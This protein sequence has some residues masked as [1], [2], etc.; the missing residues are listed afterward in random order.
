MTEGKS[1]LLIPLEDGNGSFTDLIL[2]NVLYAP[3]LKFN[4]ISTRKL[5]K[6]GTVTYLMENDRPAQLMYNGKIIGLAKTVDDQY[7]LQT[8]SSSYPSTCRHLSKEFHPH[9]A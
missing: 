1:S 9:L 4:L 5:G 6:K 8:I 3:R 2:N 7:A